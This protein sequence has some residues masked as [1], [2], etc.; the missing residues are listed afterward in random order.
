LG[1]Y[2]GLAGNNKGY[3]IDNEGSERQNKKKKYLKQRRGDVEARGEE[4]IKHTAAESRRGSQH[5][6]FNAKGSG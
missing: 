6:Y 2:R 5:R 3:R 4:D 1:R